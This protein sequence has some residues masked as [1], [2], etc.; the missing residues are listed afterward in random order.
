[1][2][3]NH[4][5]RDKTELKTYQS[6]LALEQSITSRVSGMANWPIYGLLDIDFFKS[7]NTA[8]GYEKADRKLRQI[9]DLFKGLEKQAAEKQFKYIKAL[10]PIHLSGD[11]FVLVWETESTGTVE[12]KQ[13][14][15]IAVREMVASVQNRIACGFDKTNEN[16]IAQ[17]YPEEKI[18]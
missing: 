6:L 15:M 10:H 1:M 18:P 8:L 14:I 16:L 11:E 17:K 5:D 2:L 3:D 7:Y 9:A 13:D 4:L 12:E